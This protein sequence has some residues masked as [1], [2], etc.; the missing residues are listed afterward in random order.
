[1]QRLLED[2]GLRVFSPRETFR[3][4]ARTGMIDDPESWFNFLE[5]KLISS[6]TY[7]EKKENIVLSICDDFSKEVKLFL[8]NIGVP[9]D[10]Y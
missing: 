3:I 8:K 7:D 1:M 4:A 5:K 10:Q 6:Q 9:D 2:E